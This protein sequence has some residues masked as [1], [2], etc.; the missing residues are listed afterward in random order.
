[1]LAS[2][3]HRYK[4][5][6]VISANSPLDAQRAAHS[7]AVRAGA[8]FIYWLQDILSMATRAILSKRSYLLGSLVGWYYE[9]MERS[10]LCRSDQVVIITPDFYDLTDRWRIPRERVHLVPNW[11]PLDDIPVLPRDN[12]WAGAH[13]LTNQLCVMYSGQLGM[14]HNPLILGRLAEWLQAV[15]GARLVV[16]AEGPG[17]DKLRELVKNLGL[18]N[19]LVLPFNSY[20]DVPLALASADILVALLDDHGGAYCVPSKVLTYLCSGR[21]IVLS[22]KEDNLAG[23][24]IHENQAGMV[25]RSGDSENLIKAIE[26]M[27][28]DPSLRIKMGQRGRAYAESHFDI[29]QIT[30]RFESILLGKKL[31]V[32]EGRALRIPE[33]AVS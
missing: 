31:K 20:E 33:A 15:P 19:V 12:A 10:L 21:P 24:I 32:D 29:E 9:R 7:A 16:I 4:P 23:R 27:I 13:G 11:C 17:T 14:K 26:Q 6:F 30:D 2:E 3:I 5:D 25:V 28:S 1:V 22:V 8:K 18:Q